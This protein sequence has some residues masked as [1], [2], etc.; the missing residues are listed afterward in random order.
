MLLDNWMGSRALII[1]VAVIAGFVIGIISVNPVVEAA[2][3]WKAA[4]ADL[5]NQIFGLDARITALETDSPIYEVSNTFQI[6][7]GSRFTENFSLTCLEDDWLQV[8][9]NEDSSVELEPNPVVQ[10]RDF[11]GG[12]I[13]E[14]GGK[15]RIIGVTGNAEIQDAQIFPVEI[16]ATI[17][18]LSPSS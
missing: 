17:L 7:A 10:I 4:V 9:T 1:V 13:S 6:N 15:S 5:Q 14:A 2:G 3:G 18:C 11:N 12:F 16:T 8:G